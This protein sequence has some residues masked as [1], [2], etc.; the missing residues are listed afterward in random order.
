MSG[1]P[2]RESEGVAMPYWR[3]GRSWEGWQWLGGL[4]RGLGGIGRAG[5]GG[6]GWGSWEALL[7]GWEELGGPLGGP[8]GVERDGR[9][10]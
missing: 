10:R 6:E 2:S 4:P 1:G 7:E 5:R 8:G 3:D 9:G